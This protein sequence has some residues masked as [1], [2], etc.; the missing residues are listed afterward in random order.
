MADLSRLS[1]NQITIK[2]WN[3]RQAVDG[4]ARHNVPAVGL[5]RDKV[6]EFGTAES[7]KIVRDAGIKVSSLC[8]GGFFPADTNAERAAKIE[9]NLR[10]IDEAATLGAKVLV[11]VCGGV[12][13]DGIEASRNMIFDGIAEISEHAK[14]SGVKLG[15]EPLHPMFAADRSIIC[16][17]GEANDLAEKLDAETVGVIVD[18]FHL[19]FDA[20][21]YREISRVGKRILG[22]HV[23]DWKVP[24]PDILLSRSMPGDGVIELEKL[25]TAADAAGYDDFIEVEIFNQAIWDADGDATLEK[26]CESYAKYV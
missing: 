16:S 1:L 20:Q 19:W 13:G 5:W 11:L 17:L 3:L 4:C 9:D 24:L 12:V 25:R 2:S 26:V 22:F 14:N 8:R 15:I 18:V 23:S 7:A 21:I 6:A 10:A